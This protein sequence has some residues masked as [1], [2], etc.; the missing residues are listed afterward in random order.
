MLYWICPEC[1]HEC[2]PA[3]RECPTCTAAEKA[4]PSAKTGPVVAEQTSAEI[5]SLAETFQ[6]APALGLLS[7]AS[8]RDLISSVNGHSALVSAAVLTAEAPTEEAPPAKGAIDS[9]VKPLVESAEQPEPPKK[10]EPEALSQLASLD[11]LVV[12]PSRPARSQAMKIA[13]SPVSRATKAPAIVPAQIPQAE[14]GLKTGGL[15]PVG[16]IAFQAA[17]PRPTK[18]H[19]QEVEPVPPRRRSV[20]FVREA[21]PGADVNFELAWA[22]LTKPGEVSLTPAVSA[23]NGKLNIGSEINTV[24]LHPK[25]GSLAFTSSRL[26][27]MGDALSDLLHAVEASAEELKQEAIRAIQAS[28][29]V[30]T[31]GLLLCAPLELVI[32]PAPPAEQWLRSPRIVFI[33]KS[34]RNLGFATLTAGPQQPTL[35]GPCL[36]PQL[37]N[38]TEGQAS[39]YRPRNKRTGAP[40]WMV[41]VLVAMGLF[42][43]A[44]G[45]LQYL[46]SNR[47]AKAASVAPAAPRASEPAL[48]PIP[49]VE[50]HPGARFVEVAGVRVVTAQN[51]KP[52][53]QYIVVNHSANELT[54]LNIHIAVHSADAP[55]GT[56]LFRVSSIIPSLA[57]NQSK[58]IRTDLDAG[59][60]EAS[61]PDWQSLRTD[62]LIARQ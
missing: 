4:A 2:S 60:K 25:P 41:S 18:A 40:T 24:P 47:D 46:T 31:T 34:P 61:I 56:P 21:L 59:L 42:I 23:T 10:V 5:L 26:D 55:T 48:T 50:E 54:G 9:L 51:K 22:P 19:E 45:V 37:R 58:E 3:I 16:E 1:G 17:P 13:V 14:Y 57:P 15:A 35:A 36:P 20:A 29:R 6:S 8:Y 44:G 62:I 33:P 52:Q 53:L 43:G 30:Q 28:F 12:N 7:P 11:S 39:S 32:A 38:F 49:V 27:L